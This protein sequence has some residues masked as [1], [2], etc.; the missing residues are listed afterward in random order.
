MSLSWCSKCMMFSCHKF[1]AFRFFDTSKFW[2]GHLDF[3][4][5][6]T[7]HEKKNKIIKVPYLLCCFV[8]H[9]LPSHRQ[10]LS[11]SEHTFWNWKK[12][13]ILI[14]ART[15]S[16]NHIK[17]CIRIFCVIPV[18]KQPSGFD[19]WTISGNLRWAFVI[20]FQILHWCWDCKWEMHKAYVLHFSPFTLAT[21]CLQLYE[22][23]QFIPAVS[24]L[25]Q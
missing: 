15:L 5:A 18:N 14:E 23:E 3:T 25:L 13:Q 1:G 17:N 20:I 6:L 24:C 12:N 10:C 19:W 21:V 9:V 7:W 2:H 8:L 22:L 16:P 4:V 11:L